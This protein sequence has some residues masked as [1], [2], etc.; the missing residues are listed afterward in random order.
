MTGSSRDLQWGAGGLAYE[1]AVPCS[2]LEAQPLIT[3][4]RPRLEASARGR[5][6]ILLVACCLSADGE[7]DSIGR[8]DP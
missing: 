8:G 1:Q 6:N 5:C 4:C 2:C 3:L 7:G